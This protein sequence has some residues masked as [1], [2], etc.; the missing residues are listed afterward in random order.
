M[1]HKTMIGLFAAF[2]ATLHAAPRGSSNYDIATDITDAGGS[3]AA[4]ANYTH[5]GSLGGIV[6]VSS[7]MGSIVFR[8]S[9]M[10]WSAGSGSDD[11]AESSEL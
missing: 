8:L 10:A 1:N 7:A 6:G 11:S 4:S 5:D 9:E 2:A 3:R